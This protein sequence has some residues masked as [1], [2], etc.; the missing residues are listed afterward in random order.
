MITRYFNYPWGEHP[1][2]YSRYS[3][4]YIF[5]PI[6]KDYCGTGEI[7]HEYVAKTDKTFNSFVKKI[8]TER[9]IHSSDNGYKECHKWCFEYPTKDEKGREGR[10]LVY[11][12]GFLKN[13]D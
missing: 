10:M 8:E 13:D 11:L 1:V 6:V 12:Y 2:Y 5:K 4:R 3:L 7:L 9:I